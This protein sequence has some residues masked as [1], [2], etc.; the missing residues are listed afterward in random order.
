[1]TIS[2]SGKLN[3]TNI[4]IHKRTFQGP[5]DN[6]ITSNYLRSKKYAV[7]YDVGG[8]EHNPLVHCVTCK[9]DALK[10]IENLKKAHNCN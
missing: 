10:L 8:Y 5:N 4:N 1:M 9:K 3:I 7:S 2:S 6:P